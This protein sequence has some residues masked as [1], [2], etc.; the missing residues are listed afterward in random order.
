[1]SRTGDAY[2]V[3]MST[4]A[5]RV[6]MPTHARRR[7]D[8]R[9][10]LDS[11]GVAAALVTC[12]SNV[13]YLSGFTGSHGALLVGAVGRDRLASDGRYVDQA[14]QEAPGLEFVLAREAALA[15]AETAA[16]VG[17]SLAYE[18]HHVTVEMFGR[19]ERTGVRLV[20][21]G[22]AVEGM[23]AHKDDHELE[24]IRTAC[25][26]TDTALDELRDSVRVGATERELAWRLESRFRELGADGS[27]FDPIV[28]G[29][30]N[31]AVPH[32][33][34][35]DRPLERGDLLKVDCGARYR[36]YCADTTRTWVVGPEP[37]GWQREIHDVVSRAQ[38]AGIAAL[39][40][41]APSAQVYAAA[42]AVIE[43]AGYGWAFPHGL[44]HGVGLDIHEAPMLFGG[45][46]GRLSARVPVT[47]E[48]GVYLPGRGGVRI[49]D[50]LVVRSGGAQALTCTD[51]ALL[52]VG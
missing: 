25:E 50:V 9:R 16:S 35:T 28:A 33:Q 5:Y 48:P 27:A 6:L 22:R 1:M 36:G 37:A 34:P 26:I 17:L 15:L 39:A 47:V 42:R 18:E 13:R 40:P 32:H 20:P 31:S 7:D 4:D 41:D 51:R 38:T 11:R 21:L 46:D 45:G 23:R 29:G 24:L 44:G 43:D 14:G 2:G 30:S 49:E 8:L 10:L 3:R 19:L 12:P 52:S